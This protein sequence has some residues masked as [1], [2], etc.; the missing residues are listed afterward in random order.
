MEKF[1][2]INGSDCFG[3]KCDEVEER[4]VN[5][6]ENDGEVCGQC[7]LWA[8]ALNAFDWVEVNEDGSF[9]AKP[10]PDPKKLH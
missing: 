6:V 8:R 4:K 7:S 5:E 3:R 10:K 9:S 2:C 1:K